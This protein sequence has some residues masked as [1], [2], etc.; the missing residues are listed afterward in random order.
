MCEYDKH[1][2]VVLERQFPGVSIV[3]DV[4]EIDGGMPR[5]DVLHAGYPC[6]PFSHAGKKLGTTD[7]RHL[8]PE[9]ARSI[10]ILRPRYVILENVS[11]HL[12]L[13]FDVVLA[14]LASMGFHAKWGLVRASDAGTPHKR[15]RLFVV[16]SHADSGGFKGSAAMHLERK[17]RSPNML[18]ENPTISSLYHLVRQAEETGVWQNTL[19]G[20]STAKP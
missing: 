13:G 10:R 18:R 3:P 19:P 4:R 1:C 16:A 5:V 8:W 14:D 6:Q 11:N 15:E 20:E 2:Q 12:R 17:R 9:I 7:P